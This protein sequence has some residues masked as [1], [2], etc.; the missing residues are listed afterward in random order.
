M[1]KNTE[2][3]DDRS[4]VKTLLKG[5]D[6]LDI[7]AEANRPLSVSDIA[8]AHDLDMG[9][10]HR[11]LNTFVRKRYIAQDPHTKQYFLGAKVLR[12]SRM[13]YEQHH[14]YDL[15]RSELIE[16]SGLCQETVQLSVI[17]AIPCAIL[18][19]E[20]KGSDAAAVSMAIGTQLPL[21]CSAAGKV[22][23]AM[24][25]EE[26]RERIVD[27][28]SLDNC[29]K[30]SI[31]KKQQLLAHLQDIKKQGWAEENNEF[32]EGLHAIAAPIFNVHQQPVAALSIVCPAFRYQKTK[33]HKHVAAMS[34]L[35]KRISAK[36]GDE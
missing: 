21:H 30:Q 25:E 7:V 36:L 14:I 33:M 34:E 5:L 24:H 28:L 12:L 26:V 35:A 31:T 4:V 6:L 22:L 15:S 29:T 18:V 9:T 16:L 2:S 32:S 20:I 19:D 13:F 10:V 1:T 3:A 17:S 11:F 8:E 27:N 23:L